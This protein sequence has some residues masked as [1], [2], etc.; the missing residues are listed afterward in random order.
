MWK[1]KIERQRSAV[2]LFVSFLENRS[3]FSLQLIEPEV[4]KEKDE[5]KGVTFLGVFIPPSSIFQLKLWYFLCL[6]TWSFLIGDL[7]SLIEFIMSVR[8]ASHAGS[9]YSDSGTK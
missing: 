4:I 8:K 7:I 5:K 3:D 2:I 6:F 1:H 9:W